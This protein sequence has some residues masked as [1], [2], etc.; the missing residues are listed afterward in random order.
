MVDRITPATNDQDI[1]NFAEEYGVYDPALVVH[2]EFFLQWVIED[3]FSSA[4]PRFELAGIQMVSN[5]ELYEKM[6]LRCLN[7]THSV[8]AYLGYLAA[9][10]Q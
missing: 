3:K 8:L 6:K 2:E 5:V 7:G 10:R 9:L 4:R 1:I